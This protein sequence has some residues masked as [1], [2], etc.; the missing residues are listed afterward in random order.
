MKLFAQSLVG[1]IACVA[2]SAAFAG[3]P[4][5]AAALAKPVESA[6]NT[7]ANNLGGGVTAGGKIEQ[8]VK[9]KGDVTTMA[10]GK[11]AKA[12]TSVGTMSGVTSTKG[13][14]QK[15]EIKGGVSTIAKGDGAEAETRVG[16][17][18]K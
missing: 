16:V 13:I 8:E 10:D 5:A 4:L 14:T 15:V 18:G 12:K 7:A 17:M 6:V 2:Y 9:V 1:V 11:Q 3:P